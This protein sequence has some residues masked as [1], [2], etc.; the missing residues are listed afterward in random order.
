[1]KHFIKP[2]VELTQC[3]N[4]L[5]LVNCSLYG[6]FFPFGTSFK[7]HPVLFVSSLVLMILFF[8]YKQ[9]M[10]HNLTSMFHPINK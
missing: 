7:Y 1:M 6:K 8:V 3:K 4:C 10:Y 2:I 5:G 9:G